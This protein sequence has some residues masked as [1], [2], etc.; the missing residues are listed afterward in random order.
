MRRLRGDSGTGA[1]LE[2]DD[3]GLAWADRRPGVVVV[4][5]LAPPSPE[6]IMLVAFL[7]TTTDSTWAILQ[8]DDRVR[9]RL[10]VQ[11]PRG[12]RIGS[13]VHGQRDQVRPVLV[14]PHDRDSRLTRAAPKRRQAQ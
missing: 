5:E 6:P 7:G 14:V 3:R 10:K 9:P 4:A 13:A 11:P 1:R 8:L 2:H 12:I